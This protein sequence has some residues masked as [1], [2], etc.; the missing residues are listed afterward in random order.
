MEKLIEKLKELIAKEESVEVRIGLR[1]AL[2][3]ASKAYVEQIKS[4]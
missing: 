3:E 4:N 2:L 1:I